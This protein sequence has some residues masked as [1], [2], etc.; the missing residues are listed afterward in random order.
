MAVIAKVTN[1]KSAHAALA[2]AQGNGRDKLKNDTIAWLENQGVDTSSITSRSVVSSGTNGIVPELASTQMKA[3]RVAHNQDKQVNQALRIIQSFDTTEL[4]ASNPQDWQKAND[5]GLRMAEELYP[6]YQA[7]IYTHIDGENHTLHNHIIVSKVN[8]ETGRKLRQKP[9]DAVQSAR[10]KNDEISLELGW[11]ILDRPKETVSRAEV[12]FKNKTGFSWRSEIKTRIDETLASQEATSWD[13]FKEKLAKHHIEPV[14]RGSNVTFVIDTADGQHRVR[15]NKLGTDYELETIQHELERQNQR[16]H[17][18]REL[19]DDA[20]RAV[21]QEFTVSEQSEQRVADSERKITALTRRFST[22]TRKL[23]E[24]TERVKQFIERQQERV[25]SL[26]DFGNF[27]KQFNEKTAE[28]L[29][30][31]KLVQER[32]ER[33][34]RHQKLQQQSLQRD[35]NNRGRSR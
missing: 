20:N 29:A 2:Y 24:T 15:G 7:A 11:H 30:H 32:K 9:G 31:E 8:L 25:N 22:F 23:R 34:L 21:N 28:Q 5:I 27:F 3:V 16:Q 19:V 17:Q 33:Q 35:N 4:D 12:D 14:I 13:T 26:T 6:D 1:T 10:A 18:K